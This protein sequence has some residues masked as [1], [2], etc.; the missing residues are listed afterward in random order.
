MH[1]HPS[2]QEPPG[3]VRACWMSR[4]IFSNFEFRAGV[5]IV[6]YLSGFACK[7]G[8]DRVGEKEDE[9]VLQGVGYHSEP[10]FS[11]SINS[12]PCS[13]ILVYSSHL[14]SGESAR[15]PTSP[16]LRCLAKPATVTI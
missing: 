5:G 12:L 7:S 10:S 3:N 4:T 16:R 2:T 13:S 9:F 8:T 1:P 11:T 6:S 15:P 14:P